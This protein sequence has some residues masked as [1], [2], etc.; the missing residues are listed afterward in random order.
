MSKTRV[1]NAAQLVIVCSKKQRVLKG[2]EQNEIEIIKNGSMVIDSKGIIEWVGNHEECEKKYKDEEFN[3]DIDATDKSVIP[4]FCDGHT[5]PV[6]SGDRCHEF[7]M[8]LQGATYMDIHKQGGGIQFTVKNVRKSSEKELGDLL[9]ER[10]D[11]MLMNGTTLTEAKSGYGLD[12]ENEVKMLKVLH[13][14]QHPIDIVSNYLGA[15]SVPKDEKNLDEYTKD[16]IEK[17][18]PEILKLKNQGLISPEFIDIFHEKGVFESE[19]TLKILKAGKEAGFLINFHGDE[20][21][22]VNSGII[23]NELDAIAVSHLERINDEEIG[24]M[25]EKEICGVLLPTTAY[26]LRLEY[27]PARKLID[28]GVPVSLGSDFNPNAHCMSMP[29]VMNLSCVQ[30]KMT[31]NES[32]VAATLNSAASMN[33]SKTHGSL[34]VGKFGDCIIIDSSNW[35]HII[36]ELVN[37][38]ILKVIKK[39][40]VVYEKRKNLIIKN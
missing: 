29:F 11:T 23:A 28:K 21:N 1:K 3:L 19:Q 31:M 5:H 37:S 17:Q 8:K 26:I 12:L 18:I 25:A 7:S 4:G 10:L 16:I 22:P 13:N 14:V 9:V 24:K 34:E 38:P 32:L 27:P 35:E 15:H 36:Y 30:M 33:R 40:K 6:W 20:L 2:K 39:G